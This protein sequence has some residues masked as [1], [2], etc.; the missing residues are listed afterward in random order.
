TARAQMT[1]NTFD[2]LVRDYNLVAFGNASFSGHPIEGGLAVRG[3]LSLSSTPVASDHGAGT[4]PR[5]FVS[6]TLTLQNDSHLQRGYASINAANNPHLSYSA[7][8][9]TAQNGG[10]LLLNG[11]QSNPLTNAGPANWNWATIQSQ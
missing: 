7:N 9:V 5:L 1:V 11:D 2:S 8:R 3:N 6:G 10:K 4:D